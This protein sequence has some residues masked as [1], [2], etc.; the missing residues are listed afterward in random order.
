MS[1]CIKIFWFKTGLLRLLLGLRLNINFN[2]NF[3]LS[4]MFGVRLWM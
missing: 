2:F 4:S 3:G 1:Y